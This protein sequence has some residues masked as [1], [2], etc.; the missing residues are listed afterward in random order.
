MSQITEPTVVVRRAGISWAATIPDRLIPADDRYYREPTDD[1]PLQACWAFDSYDFDNQPRVTCSIVTR[2][3]GE[4]HHL[5]QF[6]LNYG[7]QPVPAWV[8]R[9]EQDAVEAML[10]F[11]MGG[12]GRVA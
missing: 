8:P 2:R 1:G 3:D 4:L 5:A 7:R 6:D 10:R 9:P 12:A 11:L